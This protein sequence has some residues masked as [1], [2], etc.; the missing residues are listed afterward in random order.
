MSSTSILHAPFSPSQPAWL[1][2]SDEQVIETYKNKLRPDIGT[3]IHDWASHQITLFQK[4]SG[5]KEVERGVK[6]HIYEKYMLDISKL[7]NPKYGTMLLKHIRYLPGD[8]YLSTKMFVSDCIGFR[9]ESE[10]ELPL[11]DMIGGTADA[12]RYYPKENLLRVSDLK[13][14]SRPAKIEQVFTYAALYCHE[15]RLDPLKTNFETRIYQNGEIYI[16]QPEGEDINDILK[17]ILHKNEVLERFERG[18]S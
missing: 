14:G 15:Y 1:K 9:M 5:I 8:A 17:N 7:Y 4:P 18:R 6:T 10:V 3:E 11:S 16:E 13:T 2:Y 12:V